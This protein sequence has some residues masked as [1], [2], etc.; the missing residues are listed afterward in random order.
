M[1]VIFLD[2]D[3]VLN[4]AYTKD[5]APS[6]IKGIDNRNLQRLAQIVKETGAAIVLCSDW[7]LVLGDNGIPSA[8]TGDI[9]YLHKK[10]KLFNL[11]IFDQITPYYCGME[12]AITTYLKENQDISNCV[13]IAKDIIYTSNDQ[14]HFLFVQSYW[15][16]AEH[17][18]SNSKMKKAIA[19]LNGE[20]YENI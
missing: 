17:G 1:K 5:K 19:I 6:G 20:N 7:G 11:S 14:Y 15:D 2:I 18:L 9:D 12:V 13:V 3:G 16:T 10:F 8:A 4:N